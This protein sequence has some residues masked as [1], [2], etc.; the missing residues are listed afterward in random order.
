MEFVPLVKLIAKVPEPLTLVLDDSDPTPLRVP[1]DRV[2]PEASVRT[3]P[4]STV[5]V[6]LV[7]VWAPLNVVL[8]AISSVLFDVSTVTALTVAPLLLSF[9]TDPDTLA[10]ARL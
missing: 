7:T 1:P 5:K 10:I 8:A 2:I 3:A 4:L 9:S 6:P